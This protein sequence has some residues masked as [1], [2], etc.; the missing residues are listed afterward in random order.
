MFVDTHCHLDHKDYENDLE[1]VLQDALNCGVSRCVIPGADMKDL[2]RAIEISEKYE[3]VFFAIGAHPYDVSSFDKSLFEKF[4]THKK[5][6]AIGECGLDY[7]RLLE[8]NE[9]E[10][11]KNKQQEIFIKQ[12]E[13][14]IEHHKPLII[15]IR[16][17][18]FD[19]LEILKSYPKAFGVL[20]CFNA[21]S[22]LLELNERFYYGIG[23][24]STFKNAKKLIEI[25]PKIPKNRLVLETDSP[26]LTPH[27]F[28]GT[29]NS[30][31]YIPLIAQK[32]AEILSI[33][34]EELTHLSTYNAQKLF[35][36]P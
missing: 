14:S 16:E 28:R 21:D 11:Y 15:H 31:T 24:V 22:M 5:C 23:G 8:L 34:I 30:P 4:V 9:R 2:N 32:I 12:I 29:R 7:Y 20:H 6:V 1:Q 10:T 13:F 19:S 17:A 33:E 3:G 36:L 18:S 27:P 35:S 26:Y 25:L